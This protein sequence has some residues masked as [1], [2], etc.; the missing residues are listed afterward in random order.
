M[1]K[2]ENYVQEALTAF[3]G[4]TK[5]WIGKDYTNCIVKDFVSLDKPLQGM[6]IILSRILPLFCMDYL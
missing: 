3:E 1:K 2:K 4:S 6:L 5:L